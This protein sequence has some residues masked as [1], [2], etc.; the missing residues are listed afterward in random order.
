MIYSGSFDLGYTYIKPKVDL[1]SRKNPLCTRL[2][3]ITLK[4]I[5][6]VIYEAISIIRYVLNTHFMSTNKLNC[7]NDAYEYKKE[8]NQQ[9]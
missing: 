1:P 7:Q 6:S 4:R 5:K 2:N 3:D 8:L 9:T